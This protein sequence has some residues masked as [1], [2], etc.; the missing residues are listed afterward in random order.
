MP[1]SE[2]V[3]CL[4]R[5]IATV[6]GGQDREATIDRLIMDAVFQRPLL[7]WGRKVDLGKPAELIPQFGWEIGQFSHE[8]G[9]LIY[10]HPD[11][12]L[13]EEYG[14]ICFN[15]QEVESWLRELATD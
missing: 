4:L 3:G 7:S 11:S 13:P 2:L 14:D 12:P 9:T 10:R 8:R 5:T 15:R 6:E 1:L